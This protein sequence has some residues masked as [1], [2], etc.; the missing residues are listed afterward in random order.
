MCIYISTYVCIDMYVCRQRKEKKKKRKRK[1]KKNVCLHDGPTAWCSHIVALHTYLHMICMHL[2]I[3]FYFYF[4]RGKKGFISKC[5]SAPSAQAEARSMI[6][7][8]AFLRLGGKGVSA[9]GPGP[10]HVCCS[11]RT[12]VRWSSS[13]HH[14][15]N[16]SSG[17]TERGEIGDA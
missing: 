10:L 15:M 7:T 13:R 5:V 3:Y 4:R 2:S 16:G 8:R 6:H 1:E 9:E 14:K 17:A 11:L 12:Y